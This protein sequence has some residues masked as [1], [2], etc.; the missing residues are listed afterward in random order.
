MLLPLAALMERFMFITFVMIKNC[1]HSL[2]RH[3]DLLLPY[4]SAQVIAEPNESY[5]VYHLF[6]K[7][8]ILV[9]SLCF[10]GFRFNAS[11]SEALSFDL[12]NWGLVNLFEIV[13]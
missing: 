10:F 7:Y 8:P 2:T 11:Q 6:V 12:I 3:E 5:N 9:L 4:P 13:T 1:F